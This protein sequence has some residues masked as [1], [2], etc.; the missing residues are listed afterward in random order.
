MLHKHT[1]AVLPVSVALMLENGI[2]IHPLPAETGCQRSDDQP[3]LATV[4]TLIQAGAMLSCY[5]CLLVSGAFLDC[6][7]SW[8]LCCI[9]S[10]RTAVRWAHL[11]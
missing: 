10:Y 8:T 6:L 7:N 1:A 3:R 4:R 2:E 11:L 9:Q 5:A